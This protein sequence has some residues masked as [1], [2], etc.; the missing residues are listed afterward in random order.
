[1]IE[2]R[3][4][5]VVVQGDVRQNTRQALASVREVLPGAT[6]IF[7][8]FRGEPCDGLAQLCDQLVL[9]DDPGAQPAYTRSRFA[10][11][12]NLNRQIATS[13]AGLLHVRT[14]YA[15]KLR[16]DAELVAD[17]F[18]RTYVDITAIDGRERLVACSYFTRHPAGVS[19][20]LFHVSDW[21]MFGPTSRLSEFWNAAPMTLEDATWFD[22]RTH[23]PTST[24]AVRRFRARL[25]PEQY[26]TAAYANRRG[27]GVPAFLDERTP[28]L[29]AEYERFLGT[30][31]VIDRPRDLGFALPKYAHLETSLYQRI[32]CV[33]PQD[34]AAFFR[35]SLPGADVPGVLAEPRST[36]LSDRLVRGGLRAFAH[37]FRHAIIGLVLASQRVRQVFG[38]MA[39]RVMPATRTL[40]TSPRGYKQR[41]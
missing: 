19:G 18:L 36:A 2:P 31:V 6:V 4:V 28:H 24:R 35:Q 32:D 34:W 11:P 30:E 12:N 1:M 15:L 20:Y 27:Y 23:Q 17:T 9:C 21:V 38:R 26:L 14:P 33:G 41:C 22:C 10:T 39:E 25:T 16:S 40:T 29:V 3:E 37:R 7:S 5:T 8:T 13:R